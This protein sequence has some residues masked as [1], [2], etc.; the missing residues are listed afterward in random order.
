MRQ[1]TTTTPAR[2]PGRLDR[3]LRFL[4]HPHP[5]FAVRRS[6]L[7][8]WLWVGLPLGFFLGALAI[9]MVSPEAFVWYVND[10]RGFGENLTAVLF[11]LTA[12]AAAYVA[13]SDGVRQV[14]WLR[15]CFWLLAALA[16]VV[17]GEEWSWGQ[18]FFLWD[19]PEWMAA[20]NK[21][22]ETNLHNMA[23]RA[24]DQ[25]PRAIAAAVILI[26]GCLLPL[27]RARGYLGWME[28]GR[29]LAW[30]TPEVTL[31]PAAALVFAPRIFDRLQVWTGTALPPPFDISTRHHQEVQETMIAIAVFLYVLALAMRVRQYR[32]SRPG[33]A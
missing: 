31:A 19:T 7:P 32:R 22:Q 27:A 26:G 23:E 13:L 21:Q 3:A 20:V 24:L 9:R 16:V 18:H 10:E 29:V 5:Q 17:A 12:V 4:D 14:G 6:G 8:A 33:G 28:R 1:D 15:L 30:L 2:A 11:V 25:K